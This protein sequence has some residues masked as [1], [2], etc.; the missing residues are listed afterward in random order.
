MYGRGGWGG[1]AERIKGRAEG[2]H[3]SDPSG[4][5]LLD[6]RLIWAQT[7]S[8]FLLLL[9]DI[10]GLF[11]FLWGLPSWLWWLLLTTLY[12]S[13]VVYAIL[14]TTR[15]GKALLTVIKTNFDPHPWQTRVMEGT[16]FFQAVILAAGSAAVYWLFIWEWLDAWT[17]D[18]FDMTVP[19][20]NSW[21]L[22]AATLAFWNAV[23][24]KF[25]GGATVKEKKW[26]FLHL[27]AWGCGAW[28]I[29]T[30]KWTEPTLM[31][32]LVELLILACLW[33]G[34]LW[35]IIRFIHEVRDAYEPDSEE[36]S[37]L[38]VDVMDGWKV[39]PVIQGG[40]PGHGKMGDM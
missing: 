9:M 32:Y 36:H 6:F 3:I 17:R 39:P 38:G 18:F 29:R 14:G 30:L 19:V 2:R 31:F 13:V 11:L 10:G 7:M 5:L 33:A 16:I 37:S 21:L 8:I 12:A 25:G 1:L 23:L 22:V 15:V 28:G 4:G 40:K 34:T 26:W 27:A 24:L 20:I 35:A